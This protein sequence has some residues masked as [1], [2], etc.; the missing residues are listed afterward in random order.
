MLCAVYVPHALSASAEHVQGLPSHS[1]AWDFLNAL[2]ILNFALFQ[3]TLCNLQRTFT[4]YGA[5]ASF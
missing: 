3:T 5:E 2:H 1:L 4:D